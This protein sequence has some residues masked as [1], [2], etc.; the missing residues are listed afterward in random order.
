MAFKDEETKKK[1]HHEYYLKNKAKW[2]TSKY[3]E[4]K[5]LRSIKYNKWLKANETKEHKVER[6]RKQRE[7]WAK[8]PI[9]PEIRRERS[10]KTRYGLTIKDYDIMFE[11]QK[12]KCIICQRHQSELT[13]I[14]NIDHCHK[15]GKIRGLLCVSCNNTLGRLEKY[16]DR[17]LNYVGE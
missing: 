4:K 6:L 15:T 11:N 13:R 14:L 12:G 9:P 7:Y 10:L 5:R 2:Y 1:Y 16:W 8:H 17:F 3:V